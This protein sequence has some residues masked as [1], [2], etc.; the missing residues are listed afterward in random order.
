MIPDFCFIPNHFCT[1]TGEVGSNSN[2]LKTSFATSSALQAPS[3]LGAFGFIEVETGTS[4]RMGALLLEV[5]LFY[6]YIFSLK[7]PGTWASISPVSDYW[8]NWPSV[9]V[10]AFVKAAQNVEISNLEPKKNWC[11]FANVF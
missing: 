11:F 3:S 8:T 9:E 7:G 2:F 10:L 5:N 6:G 1:T 4:R